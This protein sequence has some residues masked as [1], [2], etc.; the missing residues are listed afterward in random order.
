M[1]QTI[2]ALSERAGQCENIAAPS[3]SCR[4]HR[5]RIFLRCY[6][7]YRFGSLSRTF[8][9]QSSRPEP[10]PR[11]IGS[12]TIFGM[13]IGAAG[14]GEFSD[15]FG[16]KIRSTSSTSCSSAS[17]R[18]SAR[19][20]RPSLCWL[21]AALSPGSDSA[22]NNRLPSPMPANIRRKRS[23]AASSQSFISSAA[24]ACGRSE[25][26]SCFSS[27]A[28]GRPNRGGAASGW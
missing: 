13:F 6:R 8:F 26:C 2:E 17:S 24:P 27:A 3:K 10:K 4:A 5:R 25:R 7:F 16:R 1:A 28:M 21:P 9:N 20:P 23:A 18:S 11:A 14:Q 12:A 15:R 22:P 19:L